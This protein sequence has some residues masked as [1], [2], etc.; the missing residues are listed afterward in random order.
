MGLTESEVMKVSLP[1]WTTTME[2]MAETFLFTV[3]IISSRSGCHVMRGVWIKK[4]LGNGRGNRIGECVMP[5]TYILHLFSNMRHDPVISKDGMECR[6]SMS[7]NRS[8][9][10]NFRYN[11]TPRRALH[12]CAI[13]V[14]DLAY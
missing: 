10:D 1:T 9:L 12:A 13:A 11:L 2:H 4:K 3:S 6:A 8:L 7:S 5:M 14:P